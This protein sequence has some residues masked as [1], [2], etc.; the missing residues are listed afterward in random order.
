[1]KHYTKKFM[2]L[3]IFMYKSVS[4]F[5]ASVF[6]KT[7]QLGGSRANFTIL[8]DKKY[9]QKCSS[10]LHTIS[11]KVGTMENKKVKLALIHS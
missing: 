11:F 4:D 5:L 10:C 3:H 1:M 7:E 9:A 2:Q 8:Y 6:R